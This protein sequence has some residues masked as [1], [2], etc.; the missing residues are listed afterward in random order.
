MAVQVYTFHVSYEGLE[1]KIWRELKVSSNYRMNQLGYAVLVAFDTLA[2]H[3]FQFRF[4]DQ[5]YVIPHS[6]FPKEAFDMGQ[7]R[8]SQLSLQMNEG[9]EMIYDF[10]T[11]QTFRIELVGVEDMK[12]GWG[13]KYPLISD[14]AGMGIIDDMSVFELKEMVE[15]IDRNGRTDSPFYYRDRMRPWDYRCFLIH[16]VNV[17]LKEEVRMIE[18][19]YSYF[20]MEDFSIKRR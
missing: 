12:K 11:M 5:D 18:E 16:C 7:F 19:D 17:L 3:L 9:M 14:G 20:W 1:H 6:D 10:G 13:R 15:Q 4:R 8:L 2:Y